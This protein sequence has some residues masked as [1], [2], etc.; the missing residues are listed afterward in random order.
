MHSVTGG[1]MAL[2]DLL[3]KIEQEN[4]KEVEAIISSAHEEAER[5]KGDAKKQAEAITSQ[6]IEKAKQ[7]ARKIKERSEQSAEQEAKNIVTEQ[8]NKAI[9]KAAEKVKKKIKGEM[10]KHV[11]EIVN[12]AVKEFSN[13]VD[14][15][16]IVAY[17]NG[18]YAA[19]LKQ[20]GID[21]LGSEKENPEAVLYSKDK[22][23]RLEISIDKLIEEYAQELESEVAKVVRAKAAEKIGKGKEGEM[24]KKRVKSKK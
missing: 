13:A 9:E 2:E 5:I 11:Q 15:Q 8:V 4:K 22:A 18:T 24:K 16:E 7:Q 12:Q 3:K 17:A 1:F 20:N 21:V 14:K 23:V 19:A 10:A 6:V